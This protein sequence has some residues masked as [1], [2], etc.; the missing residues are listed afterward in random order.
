MQHFNDFVENLAKKFKNLTAHHY[1]AKKQAEFFKKVKNELQ[2]GECFIVLDFAE[3]YSFLVQDATQRFY[4]NNSQETTHPFVL[5]YLGS[6]NRKFAHNSYACISDYKIHDTIT[7]YSFLKHFYEHYIN[8]EFPFVHKVFYFSDG[9]AT[10][11]KKN[12]I[13]HQEDFHVQAE[14]NFFATSHGKNACD[15]VGGTIKRLAAHASL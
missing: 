1:F 9:C 12:L 10:Q 8:I 3:N 14:W 11:Y 15:G 7:V 6:E 5:Y 13:F 4:W 2:F